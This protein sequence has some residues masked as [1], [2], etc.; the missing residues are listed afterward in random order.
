MAIIWFRTDTTVII[1][2]FLNILRLDI[3]TLVVI[4]ECF[5]V[6]S[7][8]VLMMMPFFSIPP[9]VVEHVRREFS[10]RCGYMVL[11]SF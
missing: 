2:I 11:E 10:L 4:V 8:S 3:P 9:F 6:V 5:L 1:V 7:F